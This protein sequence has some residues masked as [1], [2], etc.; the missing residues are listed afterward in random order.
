MYF[1]IRFILKR[2]EKISEK[3]TG[4]YEL[5]CFGYHALAQKRDDNSPN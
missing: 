2:L 1:A 5:L 4:S 3:D